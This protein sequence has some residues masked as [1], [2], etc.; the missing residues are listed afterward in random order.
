ML[1]AL[2]DE[3]K[4]FVWRSQAF[5]SLREG[6]S[7]TKQGQGVHEA[8][9]LWETSWDKVVDAMLERSNKSVC[10]VTDEIKTG[11]RGEDDR[12]LRYFLPP[13]SG[14]RLWLCALSL[15]YW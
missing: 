8:I 7:C 11:Q 4:G 3:Q 13:P 15:L 14:L 1:V 6:Y 5:I 12:M 2:Q 9:T 10:A